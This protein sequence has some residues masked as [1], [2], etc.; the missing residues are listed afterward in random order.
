[1]TRGAPRC[2][3][4]RTCCA[5]WRPTCCSVAAEER[6]ATELRAAC[7]RREAALLRDAALL[8]DRRPDGR[9]RRALAA[10]PLAEL[11]RAAGAA[12]RGRARA[13]APARRP[14]ARALECEALDDAA[15]PAADEDALA[16]RR[17]ALL[18]LLLEERALDRL[19]DGV[20]RPADATSGAGLALAAGG[21]LV[22]AGLLASA[23]ERAPWFAAGAAL[24]LGAA[25]LTVRDARRPSGRHAPAASR[26]RLADAR[27]RLELDDD[28][29]LVI[30]LRETEDALRAARESARTRG[31]RD[32][33]AARRARLLSDVERARESFHDARRATF[34]LL[35]EVPVAPARL[36]AG[37]PELLADVRILQ[38]ALAALDELAAPLHHLELRAARRVRRA[39]ALARRL[40]REPGNDP[41]RRVAAWADDLPDAQRAERVAEHARSALPAARE[42][43]AATRAACTE[44]ASA[45]RHLREL[46]AALAPDGDPDEGLRRAERA[47]ALRREADTLER[48]LSAEVP[49]WRDRLDEADGG[50]ESDAD[51]ASAPDS[52]DELALERERVRLD[53]LAARQL[54]ASER[55]AR[56][57]EE[58]R[59]LAEQ[60]GPDDLDGEL[61]ALHEELERV[62]V[63]H[64]RRALLAAVL[65]AA[66]ARW[67]ALHEPDVLRRASRWVERL[68]VGRWNAVL[69][70]ADGDEP[71]LLARAR[72]DDAARPV[73]EALSR[74]TRDQVRLAFRLALAERADAGE[75]LPVLL[76]EAFANWD[77]P[78]TDVAADLLRAVADERQ[79]LLFTARPELAERLAFLTGAR[80]VSLPG[81]RPCAEA[82]GARVGA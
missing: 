25:L 9:A 55:R 7:A 23:G 50:A 20:G 13:A 58:Q 38:D 8:L 65:R 41:V 76:D 54:A 43:L 63:A 77:A 17:D 1:M 70:D 80:L 48:A 73:D 47:D 67:R 29:P 22:A 11:R 51:T 57:D 79:V 39:S 62:R 46:F 4:T 45:R 68:T 19:G 42:E 49:A 15:P 33:L 71:R 18:D 61:D 64:D 78:R 3:R 2:S 52:D 53:E 66:D 10:L 34:A 74:A 32:V 81:D 12:R 69:V 27:A 82:P 24:A 75:P 30:A 40:G 72:D 31:R 36:A 14:R 59:A 21:A 5:R 37:G 35:A 44:A 56:L 16:L 6:R 26:A 28:V 60:P